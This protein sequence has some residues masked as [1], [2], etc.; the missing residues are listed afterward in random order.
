VTIEVP[1]YGGKF[2]LIDDKDGALVGAYKWYIFD[3]ARYGCGRSVYA[4]TSR[5]VK[6]HRLIIGARGGV[7]V[8]HVN[9]DG[10][11]NRRANLRLCRG[12][13]NG[14]NSQ[15]AI[16][17]TSGY[18]GVSFSIARC[19]YEAKIQVMR[20][21]IFL[22]RFGT[23]IEAAHAYDQAAVKYFGEFACTNEDLITGSAA[24]DGGD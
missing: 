19:K 11:D 2:A 8:D 12:S 1:I 21:S 23:A 15:L 9:H 18:K 6:M 5:G 10:L 14:A 24:A 17:N 3:Q 16:N 13:Q 7:S 22:G 4:T 20:K